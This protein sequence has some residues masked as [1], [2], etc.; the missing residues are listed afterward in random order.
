VHDFEAFTILL[1]SNLKHPVPNILYNER[2]KLF[3]NVSSHVLTHIN[4]YFEAWKP[5]N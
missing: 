1:L 5:A 3:Q 2:E 4:T